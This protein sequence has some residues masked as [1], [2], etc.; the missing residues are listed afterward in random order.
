MTT[1]AALARSRVTTKDVFETTKSHVNF[2][3]SDSDLE[4]RVAEALESLPEVVVA[5]V[6]GT[7]DSTPAHAPAGY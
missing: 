1:E 7:V 6:K 2:V 3:T 5:Y 4:T